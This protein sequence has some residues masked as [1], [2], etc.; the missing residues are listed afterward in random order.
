VLISWQRPRNSVEA[1]PLVL[2]LLV[3]PLVPAAITIAV[4]R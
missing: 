4:L 2:I 3:I 1:G